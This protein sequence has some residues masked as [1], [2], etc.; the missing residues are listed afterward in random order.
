MLRDK[1][2]R[3]LGLDS[4]GRQLYHVETYLE[5]LDTRLFKMQNQL[6]AIGPGLGRVIA[7]LDP[8]YGKDEQDPTRKA[9]SDALGEQ[10]MARLKAE[11]LA[12]QHTEGNL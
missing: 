1:I 7:K 10:V 12:R 5:H 2:R 11:H 8:M 9:E 4:I 6:G 3:W